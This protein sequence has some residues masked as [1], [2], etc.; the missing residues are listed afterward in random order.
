MSPLLL[1]GLK[2]ELDDARELACQVSGIVSRQAKRGRLFRFR[3]RG[4][5]S[6]LT[7]LEQTLNQFL[8]GADWSG[9]LS[10]KPRHQ[11]RHRRLIMDAHN[12]AGHVPFRR[13]Q[14]RFCRAPRR[15]YH[16]GQD[17]QRM[18]QDLS[19]YPANGNDNEKINAYS[20]QIQIFHFYRSSFIDPPLNV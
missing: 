19:Q 1:S 17:D 12:Q 7:T 18:T 15:Q 6:A 4:V 8:N 5:H 11:A 10:G 3:I 13:P 9:K 2:Q 14:Q 16:N 20:I